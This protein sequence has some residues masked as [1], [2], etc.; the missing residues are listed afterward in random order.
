MTFLQPKSWR[1]PEAAPR[2]QELVK[3]GGLWDGLYQA[4]RS[5]APADLF[6][7][8]EVDLNNWATLATQAG[9][10][11]PNGEYQVER[12]RRLLEL[13]EKAARQP[14]PFAQEHYRAVSYTHLRAHE[15]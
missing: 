14:E 9:H 2:W 5:K 6:E 3:K 8:L 1:L 4:A 13:A 12:A 11:L 7:Q 15:T 10:A